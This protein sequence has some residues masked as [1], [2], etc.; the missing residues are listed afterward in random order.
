MTGYV[1]INLERDFQIQILLV[2]SK[3]CC[4]NDIL[5][6]SEGTIPGEACRLDISSLLLAFLLPVVTLNFPASYLRG[7]R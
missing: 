5:D 2:F 3:Q 7:R 1:P 6:D 4:K